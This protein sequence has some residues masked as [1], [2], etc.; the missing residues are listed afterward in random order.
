[1]NTIPSRVWPA[2]L[3]VSLLVV[4]LT[5]A[6]ILTV[7]A[8]RDASWVG[9]EVYSGARVNSA[10]AADYDGD[11]SQE[12]IFSAAGKVFMF[13]GPD[14][15]TKQ[16]LALLDSKRPKSKA[17]CIHCVLH[18]V[19]HDG[20]LDFVGSHARGLFWLECPGDKATT[21]RWKTHQITDQIHGVHC[22]RSFDIDRDGVPDLIANDFTEGKGPYSGS[23]CWLKPVIP[24]EP[25]EMRWSIIP[26]ARGSAPGGSH[27]FDFGDVNG[28]G[29]PDF[30]LGAKGKPF[31]D[32]NY[33]AVFYAPEDPALPWRREFLP[34][35][36]GQTGAT[37]AAPA[38]VN[39]DGEPD[40]LAS[41]GHG[42]GVV[43]FEGPGWKEHVIDE[44]ILFPH[45]T[46]FGDIDGDGDI[47]LSSVGFGS[48]LAAWYEND[49]RGK[50][51]RHV[52]S[53]N[54][55]AYDTMITDL[56]GDGDMDILVAGQQS[57][58]VI[59]FENPGDGKE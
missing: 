45:S 20:D 22:I 53:R 38:D 8:E 10:T 27:Y 28:D 52:L 9:H 36:G 21:T 42:N 48:K 57:E 17:Q 14:Y 19:D 13:L 49:G 58:N 50:F 2:V 55:M 30:T 40:I 43:W 26:I 7:D 35:P 33:F 23:I 11:G 25:N 5:L 24:S 34:D 3:A 1:M 18:D 47:D 16:V 51:T 31:A 4:T 56:N 15:R 41:R 44:D 54:Q 39:G 12:I 29:R 59:W 46:D 32:G 6:R 37:H